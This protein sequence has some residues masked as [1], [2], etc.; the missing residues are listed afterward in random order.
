[1]GA[2][3]REGGRERDKR[4]EGQREGRRETRGKG[5]YTLS[6]PRNK[7]NMSASGN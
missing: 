6:L 4:G 7:M 5:T 2:K 1:M 3:R